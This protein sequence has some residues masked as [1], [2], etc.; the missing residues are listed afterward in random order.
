MGFGNIY[1]GLAKRALDLAINSVKSKGSL[2]LSRST[3]YHPEI[4]HAIAEMVL[5][6][7][8]IGPHLEAVAQDW[9]NGVDHGA[10]W[11]SKIFSAK[12]RAVE[13]SWMLSIL[14]SMSP[15]AQE[16]FA[17][18]DTNGYCGMRVWAGFILP[19]LFSRMR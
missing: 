17:P 2:G 19:I 18:R 4:Q 14:A 16:S 3:A 11:P 10:Q 9:S 8:S 6:L 13:A 15:A 7:E 5:E 1:Y 12:Y